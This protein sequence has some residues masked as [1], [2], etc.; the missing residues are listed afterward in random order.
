MTL[1]HFIKLTLW[2]KTYGTCTTHVV[3]AWKVP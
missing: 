3:L 1:I 2:E